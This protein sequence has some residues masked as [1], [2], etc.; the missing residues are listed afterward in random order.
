MT[1]RDIDRTG[2]IIDAALAAGGDSALLHG[3][4]FEVEHPESL[5]D[6]ARTAAVA[7]ARRKAETLARAAGVAL[8]PALRIIEGQE[9]PDYTPALRSMALASVAESAPT[10][11]APGEIDVA[12]AVTVTWAI[13]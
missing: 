7:Q 13:A 3:I 12:I 1:L 2:E 9:P 8:G 11:V 6:E 4:A 5:Q 10:P